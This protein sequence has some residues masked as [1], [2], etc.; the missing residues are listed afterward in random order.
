MAPHSVSDIARFRVCPHCYLLANLLVITVLSSRVII[1]TVLGLALAAVVYGAFHLVRADARLPGKVGRVTDEVDVKYVPTHVVA[2]MKRGLV[3]VEMRGDGRFLVQTTAV[4]LGKEPVE[5]VFQSG[6]VLISD[7]QMAEA[8]IPREQSIFL[9]PGEARRTNLDVAPGSC[10]NEHRV[11]PYMVS[12]HRYELL[13]PFWDYLSMH[14]EM[15]P[16]AVRTATLIIKENLPLSAFAKFTLSSGPKP[17]TVREAGLEVETRH[18]MEA[19][20]ALQKAGYPAERLAILV[21]PQLQ[22]EAMLDPLTRPA[23]KRYFALTDADEWEYWERHLKAG[24]TATRH[25]AL[26]AIAR[27]YPDVAIQMLPSWARYQEMSLPMRRAAILALA[28]VARPEAGGLLAQLEYEL[29]ANPALGD[30]ATQAMNYWDKHMKLSHGATALAFQTETS[31][32]DVGPR[33]EMVAARDQDDVVI[34]DTHGASATVPVEEG[35]IVALPP[36]D[37]EAEFQAWLA[38]F[39][40]SLPEFPSPLAFLAGRD[41]NDAS[42]EFFADLEATLNSGGDDAESIGN[43]QTLFITLSGFA[44]PG[45]AFTEAIS[46]AGMTSPGASG[47]ALALLA[48]ARL[49]VEFALAEQLTEHAELSGEGPDALQAVSEDPVASGT[50]IAARSPSGG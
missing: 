27:F 24:N 8:L 7:N 37:A 11:R 30:A 22:M 5:L 3:T 43:E 29:G 46:L 41:A 10:R 26:Y 12:V 38:A 20:M 33:L 2:A 40:E 45:A 42:R 44:L 14:P 9:K 50:V 36:A 21:D 31:H 28:E 19:L 13:E 17:D 15:G 25:Y 35:E 18:I 48:P 1:G 32:Q 23:A 49:E 6:M 34:R 47:L 16:E 4:N 39:D